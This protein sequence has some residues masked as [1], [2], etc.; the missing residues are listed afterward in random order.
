L[1]SWLQ[2]PKY[3]PVREWLIEHLRVPRYR[4]RILQPVVFLCGGKNSVSRNNVRDYF[5][6]HRPNLGVFYAERVW[7]NI[8]LHGPR[9][10]L[11]MEE[12]L[13]LLAD[14]ILI[15]VDSP[16]AFAELGAFSLSRPLRKKLL[17][18][19]DQQFVAEQ[20][21]IAT[22]P[23]RWIDRESDFKPTIYA[24]LLRI[25]EAIDQIEDRLD[26]IK[27]SEIIKIS[28]LA[29]SPKHLLF[30]LCDLI[31]VIHPAS[32]EDI[33]YYLGRIAPS[34]LSSSINIPTLIGLATAMNLLRKRTIDI[35]G[36][37][38]EFLSPAS[39]TAVEHPF[40][41]SRFLDLQRQRA[42]HMSVLLA[43]PDAKVV[44]DALKEA[45]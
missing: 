11:Q 29:T 37:Q 20:S 38:L 39:V 33:E 22:G 41:H 19:I 32:V 2:H 35:A 14:L 23:I 5:R 21:F 36:H 15:I 6:K 4:F 12:E 34:I 7:E 10:A 45:S 17:P 9:D 30:F 43:I 26:S 27:K 8:I 42:T 25:L 31:A 44:L 3:V 16:G 13:A 40:H 1:A 28:D 18:I 24:P